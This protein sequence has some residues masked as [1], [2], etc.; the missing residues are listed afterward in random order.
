MSLHR[1][2]PLIWV[3]LFTPF[4]LKFDHCRLEDDHVTAALLALAAPPAVLADAAAAALLAPTALPPVLADAAAAA[5]LALTALPPVGT[6]HGVARSLGC[7]E[8]C[9]PPKLEKSRQRSASREVIGRVARR[10]D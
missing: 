3:W 4:E 8:R 7:T 10:G 1:V 5:L 2:E 9:T 6:G